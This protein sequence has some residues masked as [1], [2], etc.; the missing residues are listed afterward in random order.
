MKVPDE[1][2]LPFLKMLF[3]IIALLMLCALAA[4]LG[5]GH[6]EEKTSYGLHDIITIL[7]V[8]SGN[9]AQW[10]FGTVKDRLSTGTGEPVEAAA[11]N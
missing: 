5:L 11:K 6:V 7:A 4:L 9:F 10:A 3:G 2:W 1:R 8:L